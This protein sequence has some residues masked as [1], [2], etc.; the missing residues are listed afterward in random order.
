MKA[1]VRIEEDQITIHIKYGTKHWK[2]QMKYVPSKAPD[3]QYTIRYASCLH[4]MLLLPD[5]LCTAARKLLKSYVPHVKLLSER[6]PDH[7][8]VV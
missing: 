8:L 6:I 7:L 4:A 5:N 3:P 1:H 2:A